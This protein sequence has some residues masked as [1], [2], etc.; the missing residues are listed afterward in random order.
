[1]LAIRHFELFNFATWGIIFPVIAWIASVFTFVYS[2]YFVFKTFAGQQKSEP[3]PI[4]PH[5]APVGMLVI[6]RHSCYARC[7][8]LLHSELDWKMVGEAGCDG[9][10]A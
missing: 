10:S 5:E 8:H 9:C 1:M 2:F 7:R 3:L 6:S 4:K